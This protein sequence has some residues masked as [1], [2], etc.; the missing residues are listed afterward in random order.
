MLFGK[1]VNNYYLKYSWLFLIGVVG[2]VAVDVF[3]LFIPEYLGK[4]IDM[5]DDGAIDKGALREIILGVMV[6]AL[7][8]FFGRIMWR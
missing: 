2:L 6:V 5:F 1:Y 3:Q 4:L 8:M 7:V